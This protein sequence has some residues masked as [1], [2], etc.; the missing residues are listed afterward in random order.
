MKNTVFTKIVMSAK[1]YAQIGTMLMNLFKVLKVCELVYRG[2]DRKENTIIEK[3]DTNIE[4]CQ[5]RGIISKKNND[6]L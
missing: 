3:R 4:G 2:K 6:K 1:K 5:K